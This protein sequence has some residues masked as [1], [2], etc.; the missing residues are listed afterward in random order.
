MSPLGGGV[1]RRAAAA[2]L[3]ASSTVTKRSRETIAIVNHTRSASKPRSAKDTS[4]S[5]TDIGRAKLRV[6]RRKRQLVF[7]CVGGE[8]KDGIRPP[9]SRRGQ[10]LASK[11][12]L[13]S[14]APPAS[15]A[16]GEDEEV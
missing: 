9:R 6:F 7:V 4:A 10:G 1:S 3:P 14:L 13:P 15:E 5:L 12:R 8:W 11:Q 16:H 2:P